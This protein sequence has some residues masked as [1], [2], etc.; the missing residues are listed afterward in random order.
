M[1]E[2]IP[3]AVLEVF[4]AEKF[5]WGNVPEWIPPVELR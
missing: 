1:T 5:E 2:I 3:K 4:K